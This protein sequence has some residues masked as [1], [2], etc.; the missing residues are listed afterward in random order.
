[1][2]AEA[3]AREMS[4]SLSPAVS[5]TP[6][7]ISTL[8]RRHLFLPILITTHHSPPTHS[9]MSG[10]TVPPPSYQGSSTSKPGYGTA[11]A[12]PL[13]QAQ[14]GAAH[15]IPSEYDDDDLADDPLDDDFKI[16]VTAAQS[17]ADVRNA[18]IR[19]VYGVLFCQV[20]KTTRMQESSRMIS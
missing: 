7:L 11:Q 6:E 2:I 17:S 18:F 14:A 13:L 1:M 19:K 20:S 15:R 3:D 12:E 4:P 5:H 9:T 10:Y 16:G 8:I